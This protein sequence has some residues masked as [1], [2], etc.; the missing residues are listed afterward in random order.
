MFLLSF[1]DFIFTLLVYYA[2]ARDGY[3]L[4]RVLQH[5][6]LTNAYIMFVL[7]FCLFLKMIVVGSYLS[8][9]TT[10]YIE[11]PQ[12]PEIV[13]MPRNHETANNA[14]SKRCKFV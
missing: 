4:T 3:I 11:L 12:E 14:R 6:E 1:L 8:T 10:I 9:V 5:H 13:S 7:C 2:L